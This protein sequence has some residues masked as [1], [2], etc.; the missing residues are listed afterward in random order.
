M[1][2]KL[3]FVYNIFSIQWMVQTLSGPNE[4]I[5]FYVTKGV[6]EIECYMT[7]RII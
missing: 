5:R 2:N 3:K 7:D 1:L 6:L 4:T